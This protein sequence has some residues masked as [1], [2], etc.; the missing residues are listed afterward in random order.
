[1]K[2]VAIIALVGLVAVVAVVI[3][4]QSGGSSGYRFAAV[5]DTANNMVAGQQVKIAGAVVGTVSSVGLAPGPKARIVMSIDE[6]FEPFRKDA[7]CTILPEGLIS[8]NYVQCDPGTTG[9]PLTAPPGQVPTVPLSQTTIPFSLQDVL[10]VF[11]LPTDQRLGLLISELGIGTAGRG[12]DLAGLIDRADPALVTS[13]QVLSILDQQRQQIAS[14]VGQTDQVLSGLA[15][16]SGQVRDFVDRAAN[17]T[18]TTAAHRASLSA[19]V[20][21]LPGML[22]AARPALRSLDT[23]ASNASPLLDYLRQSAP[24]LDSLTE[25]LPAFAN[26]G[27]PALK[28]LA[29]TAKKGRPAVKNAVPVITHLNSAANQ[30]APLT[31]QLDQLLVSL[32]STGGIE[33]TIQLVYTMAVLTSSYDSTSH[34]INFIASVAPQ[35]LAGEEAGIDIAGCSKKYDSPGE[36]TVPVNDPSCG[37]Q[38]PQDFW[39]NKVCPNALPGGIPTLATRADGSSETF[40]SKELEMNQLTNKLMS[41]RSLPTPQDKSQLGSLLSYLLK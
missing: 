22:T 14:A 38:A 31:N 29:A 6:R 4:L 26:A 39:D 41:G 36:G 2:R 24:G 23:A 11:A 15:S 32:R 9:P 10:N 21:N 33:Y 35:C 18:E 25:T 40:T 3:A 37:A 27:V 7:T 34:L 13:Q 30:L 1:M 17:V 12:Q 19:A 5:F 20:A 28:S 16:Q 8:E